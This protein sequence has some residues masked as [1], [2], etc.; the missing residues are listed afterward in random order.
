[1]ILTEFGGDISIKVNQLIGHGWQPIGGVS[2]VL[3][4]DDNTIPVF[5]QSMVFYETD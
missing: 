1:M 5:Y 2:I 3:G 4:G